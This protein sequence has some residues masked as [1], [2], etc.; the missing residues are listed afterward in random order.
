MI[1]VATPEREPPLTLTV[2]LAEGGGPL[3]DAIDAETTVT[4]QRRDDS[5]TMVSLQSN[6]FCLQQPVAA[7]AAV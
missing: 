4:E 7:A 5:I 1:T 2:H 6:R 3:S